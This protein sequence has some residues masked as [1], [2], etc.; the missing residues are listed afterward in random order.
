MAV[1]MKNYQHVCGGSIISD[2]FILTAGHCMYYIPH[3]IDSRWIV[4]S[5]SI[6]EVQYTKQ[7]SYKT[8]D[9]ELHP[10]WRPGTKFDNYDMAMVSV[11]RRI[12][13]T[14]AAI[15]ICLPKI[16]DEKLFWNQKVNIAGW[17]RIEE[18]GEQT[19]VLMETHVYLKTQRECRQLAGHI[20]YDERSMICA[21]ERNTDACQGDSGNFLRIILWFGGI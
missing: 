13:F 14:P 11:D 4:G 21:H 20:K 12:M 7:Q 16:G 9:Y 8:K 19:D 5:H 15:P 17:G 6:R 3:S 10:L 18:N 1:M 2:K